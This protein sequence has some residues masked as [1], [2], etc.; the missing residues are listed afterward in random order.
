M[1]QTSQPTATIYQFIKI[2]FSQAPSHWLI[3]LWAQKKNTVS[4][5]LCFHLWQNIPPE[6]SYD[7]DSVV[8]F[9]KLER[10]CEKLLSVSEKVFFSFL[11]YMFHF[12]FRWRALRILE[13]ELS[14]FSA[15]EWNIDGSIQVSGRKNLLHPQS[16]IELVEYHVSLIGNIPKTMFNI[17]QIELIN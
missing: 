6:V 7:F 9:W 10:G 12:L 3:P 16:W 17:L 15:G 11:R 4:K 1:Q 13:L 2:K 5:Q 14:T 8:K